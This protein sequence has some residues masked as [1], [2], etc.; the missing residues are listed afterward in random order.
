[1]TEALPGWQA[2]VITLD[3]SSARFQAFEQ[4]NPA[5]HHEVFQGLKGDCLEPQ[6]RI[7][8]GLITAELAASGLL[9]EGTFGCAIS[10]RHLW[11]MATSSAG[12][13]LILEDDVITH[14]ALPEWV[15]RHH[16]QLLEHHITHFGINTDSVLTTLS[17]QGLV[18]SRVFQ[19]KQPNHGWIRQALVATSLAEVRPMR[20]LKAFG[21][22][23]YFVS[24]AGA[25]K[26]LDTTFPL[27]MEASPIPL[28]SQAM[29]GFSID[30]RLNAFY[31]SLLATITVPFLAYSPNSDSSTKQEAPQA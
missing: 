11:Q 14:P 7:N 17:A 6:E 1:M 12:G 13:L 25:R 29:P 2:R 24:P 8:Q 21:M 22:C 23:C 31:P 15:N 5:L 9:S 4:H 18:E 26:L 16:R 3:P 28:V 19:P 20:L 27:T 10:H 30:R